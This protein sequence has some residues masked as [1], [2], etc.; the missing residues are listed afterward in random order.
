[1]ESISAAKAALHVVRAAPDEPIT[2]DPSLELVLVAGHDVHVAVKEHRDRRI[3]GSGIG[4]ENRQV[5]HGQLVNGHVPSLE[6]AT[7]EPRAEPYALRGRRIE[8]DQLLGEKTLV[9]TDESSGRRG[10]G[11]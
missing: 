4:D 9:Q 5:T 3:D 1:M 8:A 11:R 10:R 6:P 2:L 7:H